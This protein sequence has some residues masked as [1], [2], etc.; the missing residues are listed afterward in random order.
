[1]ITYGR[2]RGQNRGELD[3]LFSSSLSNTPTT[4]LSATPPI[5]IFQEETHETAT[6]SASDKYVSLKRRKVNKNTQAGKDASLIKNIQAGHPEDVAF[7]FQS[8]SCGESTVQNH[9]N[10]GSLF[11][12]S[13]WS[14]EREARC[15]NWLLDSLQFRERATSTHLLYHH[16]Y[17]KVFYIESSALI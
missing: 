2:N 7:L 11:F 1:M 8:M 15:R 12:P 14:T 16:P 17:Y 6:V 4:V 9:L 3:P 10:D 13:T 5:D